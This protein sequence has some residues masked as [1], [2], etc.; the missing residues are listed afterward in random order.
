MRITLQINALMSAA[1]NTAQRRG[2][3]LIDVRRTV[4]NETSGRTLEAFIPTL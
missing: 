1:L 4:S 3:E 2:D